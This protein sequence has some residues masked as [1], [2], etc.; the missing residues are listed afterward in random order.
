MSEEILHRRREGDVEILSFNRPSSRNALTPELADALAGALDDAKMNPAVRAVVLTGNGGSFCSGIDLSGVMGMFAEDPSP[1]K[2]RALSKRVLAG[3]LH[4]AIRALW[5]LPKP[6]VAAVEGGAAGFGLDLACA[7]DLRVIARDAKLSYT[8]TRRGLVPD[9]G[10]GH[11]LPRM[12]GLGRALELV[13]LGE[14]FD[15]TRAL[16][17]GL[18][19]R[20]AD[21]AST[22]PAAVELAAR[23]GANA[24]LAMAAAKARLKAND[25]YAE[26]LSQVI[27]LAAVG[28]GSDDALEGIAAFLEKR[29]P[30]FKG[31]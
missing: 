21:G 24:P 12:I 8:F 26:E 1:A 23:L 16:E 15:G 17:L 4:A 18:A 31:A 7:C 3:Q 25:S 28:V 11:Y 10:T 19:N 14:P 9:G 5:E 27:E 6:T 30:R 29:P 20:V 2:R 13:L 22:L